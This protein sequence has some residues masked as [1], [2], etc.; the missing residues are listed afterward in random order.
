MGEEKVND[1]AG[2]VALCS[3]GIRDHLVEP[4]MLEYLLRLQESDTTGRRVLLITEEPAPTELPPALAERLMRAR[5]EWRPVRYDPRA[6]GQWRAKLA[7]GWRIWRAARRFLRPFDRRIV[8][9][10]LSLAGIYAAALGRLGGWRSIT[11]CFEPHSRYMRELGIWRRGG[12]KDRV[13]GL[14]ERWQAR[15]QDVLIVP[16]TAVRDYARA[17]GRTRPTPLQAIT[18]DVGAARFDPGARAAHRRSLGLE[19]A[20]VLVYAGKFGGLYHGIDDYLRFMATACEAAPDAHHLIITQPE[21][22]ERLLAHPAAARLRGRF[23]LLPP[24]P[25]EQLPGLLSAADLGVVA[26]PPSPAQAFRTPV[27]SAYYWAAGLPILIPRGVSDDHRIAEAEQVGIVV[28]DLPAAGSDA[29]ATAI[30]R[31]RAMDAEALRRRCMDAALRHRDTAR[32][33]EALRAAMG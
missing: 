31:Y 14:L 17:L 16:T 2:L 8:A 3:L 28:D 20:F 7:N 1:A 11:V 18:I 19:D 6:P 21:W 10:Y 26:I 24:V 4:L 23:T 25:P 30:A 12:L 29:L 5:V 15:R 22:I 27:K 13:V 9:G 32:M 33:V